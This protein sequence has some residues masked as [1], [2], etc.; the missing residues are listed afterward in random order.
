M[1]YIQ[2]GLG[3]FEGILYA[4]LLRLSWIYTTI[5]HAQI[6]YIGVIPDAEVTPDMGRC[7]ILRCEKNARKI[8]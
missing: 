4:T 1:L 5:V 8:C 3:W 2:V 6:R 7:E